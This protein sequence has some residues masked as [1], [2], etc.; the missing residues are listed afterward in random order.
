M[1]RRPP[2]ALLLIVWAALPVAGAGAAGDRPQWTLDAAVGY[3]S[4][5]HAYSLATT[6][7]SETV[8][9]TR[10]VLAWEGRS[11]GGGRADWRLRLEGSA[12]TDLWRESLEAAWRR[13]D[14]RGVERVRIGGRLA[15]RQY[16]SG[17]D[18]ALASDQG[19][20]R[21]D[22]AVVPWAA[23]GREGQVLGWTAATRYELASPLEQD[24]TEAGLGV[25]L[26]SRG[27][28]ASAWR[29]ALKHAV[30]SYPDSTVIDRRTWSLDLDWSGTLGAA[31]LARLYGRSERR[32]AREPAVRPDAWLHWLQAA[33]EFPAAGGDVL[34]EAEA[35]SWRYGAPSEVW[36]DSRRG[37]CFIG[38]RRG[39]A[40]AGQ[41]RLGLAGEAFDSER[42]AESYLQG[43]VRGGF[44]AY[45]D[46]VSGSVVLE[47][48]RRSYGPQDADESQPAWTDFAY[49]RLWL[50]ADWRLSRTLTLS[51]L[52]N[53]EPERHGESQDDVALGFASLRLAWRR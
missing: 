3:D 33:V 8:S 43:G 44:E 9:E 2:V 11:A 28:S 32:L 50:L 48:G 30:R 20:G 24:Q 22:A 12:G 37:A 34:V 52:G 13:R 53:W 7:T 47:H 6:D 15:G 25:A 1:A 26:R 23:G 38:L 36:V 40:L 18:Y 27:A 5:T 46:A 21:L 45:G 39:D 41:W 14:A 17:T 51:A 4:F 10:A 29:L 31:G 16:R 19:E 42:D 35:E 49:W